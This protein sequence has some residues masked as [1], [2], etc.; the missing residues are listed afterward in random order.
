MVS[1]VFPV[2][3]QIVPFSFG[4]GTV[5]EGDIAQ[6]TCL[7]NRGDEPLTITWFLK[8]DVVSS[9]PSITTNMF[10]TRASLLMISNVGYRHTGTYACK[11]TNAA[12]SQTAF[13]TLKVNGNFSIESTIMADRNALEYKLHITNSICNKLGLLVFD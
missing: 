6:L 12:G 8:G 1:S 11:A 9:E 4:D 13:A 10:G 2:P 7:V 5:N 3:P